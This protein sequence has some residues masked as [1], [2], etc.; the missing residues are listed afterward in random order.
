MDTIVTLT[1]GL[2]CKFNTNVGFVLSSLISI[3]ESTCQSVLL[4]LMIV[5]S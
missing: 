4:N 5:I 2:S 1:L 3:A